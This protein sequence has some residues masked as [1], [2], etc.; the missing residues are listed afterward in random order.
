MIPAKP[1]PFGFINDTWAPTTTFNAPE[2]R[3]TRTAVWTGSE[4]IVWGGSNFDTGA[5]NTGARYNPVTDTWTAT[6]TINAP[7][8][9]GGQS[10]VWTGTELIIW[11]G[12]SS[13]GYLNSGSRYDPVTDTWTPITTVNAPAARSS[14]N[15]VWTGTEMIVWGGR[16]CNNNC[17]LNSGGRY[18][19]VTDSWTAISTSNAPSPRFKFTVVWAGNEMIVWGGTD[20]IPNAALLRTGGRYNPATDT[21]TPTSLVNVPIGRHDQSGVWTGSE[22]LVWGGVDDFSNATNTGGRYNPHTDNWTPTNIVGAPAARAAH[23]AVWTGREMIIWGGTSAQ[24]DFDTGSRYDP[25]TDNWTTMSTVNTPFARADHTAVWTGTEMIVWGGINYDAG[26]LLNTGGRYCARPSTPLVQGAVSRKV[27]G[28]A[29]SLDID[30]P[31]SGAPAVES[32]SGG[33]TGDYNIVVTFLANVSVQ[34]TPQAIIAAGTAAIG[35]SG[36]D[37]GGMVVT[38]GNVVTI[39]LTNVA[40]AQ[41]ISVTLKS[42]NGSTDVT[43]PMRVLLGDVNGNGAVNATDIGLVKASSGQPVSAT[44]FRADVDANG[45]I[46]A[47]DI[48]LVKAFSGTGIP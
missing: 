30:L 22:M 46:T 2:E 19:P 24:P 15:A 18:N 38:A 28:T 36:V 10:A 11:G 9:R 44:N 45:N 7:T 29:G 14:H 16:G 1:N 5:L 39:P 40:N 27:H 12:G 43:I 33:A 37:N 34:G 41:T 26:I 8:P 31:L 23:S 13:G 25:A 32:R 6:S 47:S 17:N 21:W 42:V 3:T 35:R 4:M 48:S 20:A